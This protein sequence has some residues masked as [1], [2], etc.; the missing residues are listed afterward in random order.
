MSRGHFSRQSSALE[1]KTVKLDG[2]LHTVDSDLE[3]MKNKNT[4]HSTYERYKANL[5]A[6]FDGRAPLP[7][8]IREIADLREGITAAS[9]EATVE[10]EK[11]EKIEAPVKN[12]RRLSPTQNN[13]SLFTEALKK[14]STHDEMRGAVSALKEANHPFPA[15]EDLLSKALTYPDEGVVLEVLDQ[16]EALLDSHPSKNP[17]LLASRLEDAAFLSRPGL[18]KDRILKIKA[19]LKA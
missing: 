18:A 12:L 13:Y 6:I 7:T 9:D 8:H 14:A 3:R 16:M 10:E 1:L 19:K 15:D 4:S 2:K 17:R 11:D 5:H